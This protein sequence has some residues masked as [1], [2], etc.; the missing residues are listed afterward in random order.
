MLQINNFNKVSDMLFLFVM[1]IKETTL[2][3]F[4][5]PHEKETKECQ[6]TF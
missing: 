4:C 3:D 1:L 5:F 2:E 6:D